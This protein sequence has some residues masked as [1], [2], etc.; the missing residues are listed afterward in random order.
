M[1]DSVIQNLPLGDG[2]RCLA[3]HA[4]GLVALEK[5]IG[6][7]AHPNRPGD[8]DQALLKAQYDLETEC[9]QWRGK[10]GP[11]RFW[12]CNRLDS[13]TS[14]VLIGAVEEEVARL[15]RLAFARHEVRKIYRAV[16]LG[17]PMRHQEIWTD[18]LQ[19]VRKGGKVRARSGKGKG[20][21]IARTRM[22]Y[23]KKDYDGTGLSL[24]QLQPLTGRTHQLR[25]QCGMRR[26]PILGDRTYGDFAYNRRFF[27]DFPGQER[28]FLHAAETGLDL[29]VDGE[30]V[31]FSAKADMPGVFAQVLRHKRGIGRER[32]DHRPAKSL[33][34]PERD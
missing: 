5:P 21:S 1:D 12:L 19:R 13:P 7:L 32:F 20:G 22:R 8:R 28:L 18:N 30:R 25:V 24:L 10:N 6:L 29:T 4:C 14:G 16:V 33:F 34:F 3:S 23:L 11:G 27:A 9:Y 26:L 31:R 2:V 17:K 15:V